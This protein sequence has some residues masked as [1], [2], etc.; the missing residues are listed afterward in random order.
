[1]SCL[2]PDKIAQKAVA[3]AVSKTK[4]SFDK[5]MVLSFL[6]GVYIA[7]GGFM[8]TTVT[9]DAAMFVGV[10]LSKLAGGIVFA[11]GLTL[12]VVAG[13]ELFTGNCLMP[14]AF[15]CG[16]T[17]MSTIVKNWILVYFCNMAGCILCAA[18]VYQSGL[19]SGPCGGYAIRI[20]ASKVSLAFG[21]AFFRGI[22]CNWLVVLAV[23]MSYGAEST[24]EKYVCCLIPVAAFVS[25]G[26]EHSIANMY[27]ITLGI[28]AKTDAFAL[29]N[30]AVNND[31]LSNLDIV[32]YIS[33]LIPV[34]LGNIV[35]GALFVALPYFVSYRAALRDGIAEGGR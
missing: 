22:L 32:G 18:L 21:Q 23:W 5:M 19:A 9:M 24:V 10:G 2:S 33:N 20:A 7:F 15:F 13:G 14:I 27:F 12:I 28:L 3:L 16:Q 35:G 26:F 6:G 29:A 30:A 25:M 8:M 11:T 4:F 17:R 31:V 1:M 34:T